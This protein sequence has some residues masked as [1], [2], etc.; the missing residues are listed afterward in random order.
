MFL[1]GYVVKK[2]AHAGSDHAEFRI[3]AA[4]AR[5]QTTRCGEIPRL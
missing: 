3:R 5:Y 2:P 4:A 1:A